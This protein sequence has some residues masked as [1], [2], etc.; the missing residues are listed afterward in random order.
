[1]RNL[2][3]VGSEYCKFGVSETKQFAR[4]LLVHLEQRCAN[5]NEPL[6]IGISGCPHGCAHPNLADIGLV[7]CIVKDAADRRVAGYELHL[8]GRIHGSGSRFAAK[9]GI[10]LAPDQVPVYL[11]TLLKDYLDS[12]QHQSVGDYLYKLALD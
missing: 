3:C 9:T 4:N 10:K 1:L 8:G 5:F 12:A 7:G 2:A 6:S 11:E